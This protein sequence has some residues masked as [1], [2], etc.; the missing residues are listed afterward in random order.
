MAPNPW[1]YHE[2]RPVAEHHPETPNSG[3]PRVHVFCAAGHLLENRH[4]DDWP[5]SYFERMLR[6]PAF[7]YR[8]C[9]RITRRV[10]DVPDAL[11]KR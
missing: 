1:L 4:A 2:G 10:R 9:K 8:C 11:R 5:G 7:T 6:D 3:G